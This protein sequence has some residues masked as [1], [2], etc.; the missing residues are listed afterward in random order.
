[1]EYPLLNTL[2]RGVFRRDLE[3]PT[4]L[5]FK[6]EFGI[7]KGQSLFGD[8]MFTFPAHNNKIEGS[9]LYDHMPDRKSVV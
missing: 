7:I 3:D 4:A 5:A 9:I 2:R 1:M 6:V 8:K